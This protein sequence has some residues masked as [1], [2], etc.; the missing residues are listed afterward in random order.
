ML[1]HLWNTIRQLVSEP[2]HFSCCRMTEENRKTRE[3]SEGSKE[4]QATLGPTSDSNDAQM[5]M[6]KMHDLSFMLDSHLSIPPK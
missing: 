1:Y 3:N 2:L 4:S 5:M 6:A